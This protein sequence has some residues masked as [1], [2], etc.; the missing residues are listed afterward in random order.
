MRMKGRV[1]REDAYKKLDQYQSEYN[2][3]NKTRI[4]I[5][6]VDGSIFHPRHE[7][8]KKKSIYT[9]KF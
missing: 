5:S 3:M 4:I 9:H 7:N 6:K 1:P 2:L 8:E